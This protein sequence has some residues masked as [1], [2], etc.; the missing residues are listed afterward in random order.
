[1][2]TGVATGMATAP[3]T[4]AA[5]R[6]AD[7][8]PGVTGRLSLVME[9]ANTRLNGVHRA[10]AVLEEF[11]RQ[12]AQVR[13][14]VVPD[15]VTPDAQAFLRGLRPR[16]ELVVVSGVAVD[17]EAEAWMRALPAEAFD[18]TLV[19][20][21]GRD[22]YPLKNQGIRRTTG[23]FVLCIDSDVLPD[24]GWLARLLGALA[25]PQVQAVAGQPYIPGVDLFSRAF[26]LGWTYDRRRPAP[27]LTR[28]GKKFYSNN[29][30]FR[31]PVIRP[32]GFPGIGA[33]TRGASTRLRVALARRGITIWMSNAAF[34]A[35][36]PPSSFAGMVER[37]LAHGRD[38]SMRHGEGRTWRGLAYSTGTAWR[39]LRRC[40]RACFTEGDHVGLPRWQIP[41]VVGI[42]SFYYAVFALGAVYTYLHPR[43]AARRFRV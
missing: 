4:E 7:A 33:A 25:D 16:V 29:I 35:H 41:G 1:M 19:H 2:A 24:P 14:G 8:D 9:W 39:R 40:V 6:A 15:D 11:A 38:K 27:G 34:V 12:W 42:M 23:E 20:E 28:K 3:T 26:A 31:A 13:D 21:Q 30:V 17:A 5:V 18:L 37:A 32:D 10:R 43:G 36:P 22:Y